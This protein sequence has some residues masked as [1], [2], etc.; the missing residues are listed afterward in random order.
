MHIKK[1]IPMVIAFFAIPLFMMAQVT[2]ST[3]SGTVK[4]DKGS[5]LDGA[6]VKVTNTQN[7][8]VKQT[9]SDKSGRFSIPNLDP[10]GPYTVAVTFVGQIIPTRENI[11]LQLGTDEVLDFLGTSS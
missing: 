3:I 6:T 11:F 10:G 7:G 2:T 5:V 8:A 1:I 9:K 4:D